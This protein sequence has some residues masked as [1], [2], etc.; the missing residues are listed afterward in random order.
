M[1]PSDLHIWEKRMLDVRNLNVWYGKQQVLHDVE[2]KVAQGEV[3]TLIGPNAAGKSTTLRT[4]IGLKKEETG[5]VSFFDAGIEK[6]DCVDRIRKGLV[7]VPEGRQVFTKSTVLDNLRIGAFSRADRDHIQSDL[8]QIFELFP[9]LEER[10]SQKA[11]TLSGGEQQMLAIARGLL[12]KPKIILLD[13]PTLGLAPIVVEELKELIR[14]LAKTGIGI[15]LAEQN[16]NMALACSD[17][18]YVLK[19]GRIIFD[20]SATDIGDS[21]QLAEMYLE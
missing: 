9:R 21:A 20:G 14:N 5:S 1:M 4:L 8:E 18:A 13:E 6:L 19:A 16:A 10:L 11:G 2:L 15:L 3:C 17:R 7:L 12:S